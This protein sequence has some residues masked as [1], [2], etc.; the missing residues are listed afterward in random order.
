MLMIPLNLA[1]WIESSYNFIISSCF[2]SITLLEVVG[3]SKVALKLSARMFTT[4]TTDV[5]YVY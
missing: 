1:V 5:L 3:S 4:T 2:Y